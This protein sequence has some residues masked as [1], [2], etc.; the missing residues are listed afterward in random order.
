[1]LEH[2]A[3]TDTA[4]WTKTAK[5]WEAW[6]SCDLYDRPLIIGSRPDPDAVDERPA[7]YNGSQARYWFDSQIMLEKNIHS[8]NHSI[9]YGEAIPRFDT[10][11]SV[12]FSMLYGCKP[13]FN[14]HASWCHEIEVADSVYPRIEIDEKSPWLY[15]LLNSH[16]AISEASNRRYF[17]SPVM[18]GNHSAD[19]LSVIRGINNLMLDIADNPTWVKT[20]LRQIT[21]DQINV[22]ARMAYLDESCGLPGTT[23]YCGTWSPCSSL[24]FDCDISCMVSPDVY[25]EMFLPPLLNIMDTVDHRIYH[26]DG[27]GAIKHLDTLLDLKGLQAI[28]WVPGDGHWDI[29]QWIPLIQKIQSAGKSVLIYAESE[30]IRTLLSELKA[31]GLCICTSSRTAHDEEFIFNEINTFYKS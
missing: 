3:I 26:L 30:H 13:C 7:G 16:M 20:A 10:R 28:Q 11:W 23:N 2:K 22:F 21:E 29:I 1:M 9:L 5:R 8:I 25:R 24:S 18:W 31:E 19:Q 6:W 15:W 17:T 14:E 27:P 12:A 4:D